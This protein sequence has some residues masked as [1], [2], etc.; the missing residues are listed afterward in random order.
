MHFTTG[1]LRH[2][3]HREMQYLRRWI[4]KSDLF[5]DEV[6]GGKNALHRGDGGNAEGRACHEFRVGVK[7]LF[8]GRFKYFGTFEIAK[9]RERGIN[10]Q[11]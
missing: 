4:G 7:Q 3:G 2:R 9:C 1:T 5:E 10:V 8:E 11:S 6:H